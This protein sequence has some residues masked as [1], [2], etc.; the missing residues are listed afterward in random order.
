MKKCICAVLAMLVLCGCMAQQ[1][2]QYALSMFVMDTVVD[3]QIWGEDDWK[4]TEAVRSLLQELERTWSVT[5]AE[6]FLSGLNRGEGTPDTK[7]QALLDRAEELSRQTRGA[8]DPKLHSLLQLWGFADKNYR[9]PTQQELAGARQ[10]A[11]WNLG[12]ILKGY[13]GEEAVAIL[14]AMQVERAILNLGGNVQTYGHKP[15]GE[16]WYIAIQ[17]PAG[18]D[19]VGQVAVEG[20]AAVVTSGDYQRYFEENGKRYHHILD[21]ETGC[22]AENELTSVTVICQSGTRADALSTALFVMGKAEAEAFWRENRDFEMVLILKDG[23]IFATAG[24]AFAGGEWEVI[25]P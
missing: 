25:Q 21:P 14:Q 24:A 7:Q 9:V 11:Q 5:D 17:N 10:S 18:G 13:A 3:I 15:D 8:F 6:S 16:P 1:P 2:G 12:G 19:A 22:P 23:S 4:A 20:T